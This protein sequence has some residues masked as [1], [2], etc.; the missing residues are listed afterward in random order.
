MQEAG[1]HECLLLHMEDGEEEQEEEGAGPR[2]ASQT[3][4]KRK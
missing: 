4:R 1:E 3:E 2:A